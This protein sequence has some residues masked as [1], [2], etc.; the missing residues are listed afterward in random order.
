[1]TALKS[2]WVDGD[3]VHATDQNTIA[4]AVNSLSGGRTNRYDQVRNVY[5]WK[6]TNTRKLRASLGKAAACS[7]AWDSARSCS[8]SW[9][10][11]AL[12]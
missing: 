3:T 5:N 8:P 10:G 1:V 4:T 2:D 9:R 11:S 7:S 6:P 12:S